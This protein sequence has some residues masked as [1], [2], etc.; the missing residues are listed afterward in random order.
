MPYKGQEIAYMEIIYYCPVED[1]EF[2][3]D[4]IMDE[5]LREFRDSYREAN[6]LLKTDEIINIRSIYGLTQKEYANLLGLG[7]VTIQR[8]EKKAIQDSTYDMIM[9]LTRENPNYCLQMLEKNKENFEKVRYTEIRNSILAKIKLYGE[10]HFA[11]E[12][13]QMKYLDFEEET[14]QNGYVILDIDK[15][16]LVANYIS[17]Y[18]DALY[19][20]KLMKLLWYVDQLS[21]KKYGKAMTGLVYQH[22]PLGALPIA[23]YDLMKL[24]AI[25]VEEEEFEDCT[26]YKILPAKDISITALRFEEISVIQEVLNKFRSFTT[27]ELV[28]YMHKER[29][30]V[31]TEEKEIMP[32]SKEY[33]IEDF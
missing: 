8:Y 26:S 9:R 30:Y 24:S 18:V 14:D 33:L 25:E 27:K 13:I 32:F 23:H 6:G 12:S 21:F 29:I 4:Y 17:H 10:D 3:P 31:A 22:R 11:K 20:V 1:G 28:D 16:S 5:N 7:D 15:V 19:K 2:V